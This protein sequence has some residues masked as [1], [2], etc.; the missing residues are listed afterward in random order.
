MVVE[1]GH[2]C[3]V[4]EE[5]A[6]ESAQ[7]STA[8]T[9]TTTVLCGTGFFGLPGHG[10]PGTWGLSSQNSSYPSVANFERR[11]HLGRRRDAGRYASFALH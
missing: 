6:Q 2:G 9:T 10:H 1:F 3:G 11:E 8:T 5:E 7:E 4:G